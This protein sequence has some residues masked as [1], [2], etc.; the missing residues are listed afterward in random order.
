MQADT[1][2]IKMQLTTIVKSRVWYII[3]WRMSEISC[4]VT[5][6]VITDCNLASNTSNGFPQMTKT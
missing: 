3:N 2:P 6:S 5:P 4:I 1:V